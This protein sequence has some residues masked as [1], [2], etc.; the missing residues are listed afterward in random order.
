MYNYRDIEQQVVE[1]ETWDR[2]Y[3][4]KPCISLLVMVCDKARAGTRQ[5]FDEPR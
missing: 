2:E 1:A 4:Y 3:S 5:Q